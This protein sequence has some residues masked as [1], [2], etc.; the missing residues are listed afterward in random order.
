MTN[1]SI[2]ELVVKNSGND[3]V[4]LAHLLFCWLFPKQYI[5]DDLPNS[6]SQKL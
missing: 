4:N 1:L 3:D 6:V 2:G 5:A